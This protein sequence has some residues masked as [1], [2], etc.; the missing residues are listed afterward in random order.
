MPTATT[1]SVELLRQLIMYDP[2]RRLSAADGLRHKFF[3]EI[4][5]R[6][7]SCLPSVCEEFNCCSTVV[8]YNP[9]ANSKR[10]LYQFLNF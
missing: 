3:A 10:N 5:S 7:L 8:E 2:E 1:K 4:A 9:N 6:Q